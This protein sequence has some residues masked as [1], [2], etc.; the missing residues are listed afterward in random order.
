MDVV[1]GALSSGNQNT[2]GIIMSKYAV[3]RSIRNLQSVVAASSL[4]LFSLVG[5]ATQAQITNS[6]SAFPIEA[7]GAYTTPDEWTDVTPAWFI[8]DP[9]TGATPTF[10]GDP[11]A[12]SLLFAS[13]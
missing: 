9:A 13:L 1:L 2:K 3:P 5:T 6:I 12:N 7:D 4:S 10:A 11:N 8:S